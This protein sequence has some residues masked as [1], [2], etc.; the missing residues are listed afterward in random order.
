ME[1]MCTKYSGVDRG[2]GYDVETMCIVGVGEGKTRT[3]QEKWREDSRGA[4]HRVSLPDIKSM[5]DDAM[6]LPPSFHRSVGSA[7]PTTTPDL[8]PP[9]GIHTSRSTR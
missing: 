8:S 6:R 3:R 7:K 9:A 5:K 4:F 2:G 1:T